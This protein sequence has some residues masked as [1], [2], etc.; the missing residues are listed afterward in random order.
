[1]L[2]VSTL[3][4]IAALRESHSIECKLAQ[5]RDGN[6]QLPKDMWETY[7]AFA[8]TQGGDI[9]LGLKENVDGSF[10][11]AGVI[12][13]Q[14]VLGQLWATLNNIEKVSANILQKQWVNV[15]PIDGKQIIHIHVP[16]AS[17][18][19]P[20]LYINGNP[21]TGTY[22]RFGSTDRHVS[23]ESVRRTFAED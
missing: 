5:G 3:E 23:E 11:L 10:T 15:I 1:M 13:T 20:P 2:K 17:H 4:D 7:S 12:N 18:L 16:R 14:K 19:S 9:F 6:G 22:Q 21:L 8:N